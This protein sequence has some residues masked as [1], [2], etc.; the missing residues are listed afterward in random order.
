[1]NKGKPCIPNRYAYTGREWD[2][3]LDLYFYRAR[4]YDPDTKRFTQE[5]EV[6]SSHSQYMYVSNNTLIY[7]D[8]FGRFKF[9]GGNWHRGEKGDHPGDPIHY[10]AEGGKYSG[11]K[12]EPSTGMWKKPGSEWEKAPNKFQKKW[13]KSFKEFEQQ[14]KKLIKELAEELGAPAGGGYT[15]LDAYCNQNPSDCVRMACELYGGS[16]CYE[17]LKDKYEELTDEED[18]EGPCD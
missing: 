9:Q 2:P 5:D 7:I 8:P 3:D 1:M 12:Y 13:T 4:W 11:Y 15:S 14:R 17:L 16:G 18:K 10:H 6:F